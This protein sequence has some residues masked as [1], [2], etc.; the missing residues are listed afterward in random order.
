MEFK[1]FED[2][3]PAIKY[4]IRENFVYNMHA[5]P[6]NVDNVTSKASIGL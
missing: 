1:L 3:F 2:F 6:K 4:S 5:Y